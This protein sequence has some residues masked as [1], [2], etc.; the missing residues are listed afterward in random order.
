MCY[1]YVY[2]YIYTYIERERERTQALSPW[3]KCSWETWSSPWSSRSKSSCTVDAIYIYIYVYVS[4][5]LS[6]KKTNNICIH[7]CQRPL[8]QLNTEVIVCVQVRL[9]TRPWAGRPVFSPGGG[10][11]RA[12]SA[13]AHKSLVDIKLEPKWSHVL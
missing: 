4:L 13:P 8:Y 3:R 11:A 6:I 1:V 5:S 10:R 7:I 9:K 2:I 12:R